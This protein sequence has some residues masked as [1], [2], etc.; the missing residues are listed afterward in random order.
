MLYS[1]EAQKWHPRLARL[2]WC[3]RKRGLAAGGLRDFSSGQSPTAWS[4]V[5][6][7]SASQVLPP[8]FH[9][10]GCYLVLILSNPA[11]AIGNTPA[12]VRP[13]VFSHP[14]KSFN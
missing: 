12:L 6:R 7:W 1:P 13:F 10:R 8:H 9:G 3:C 14:Q 5:L 11:P 2:P 4:L